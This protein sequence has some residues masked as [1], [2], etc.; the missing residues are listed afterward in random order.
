MIRAQ[1]ADCLRDGDGEDLFAA[2]EA[3]RSLLVDIADVATSDLLNVSPGAEKWYRSVI[4]RA[5]LRSD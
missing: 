4:D 1:L 5:T 2:Y 3:A